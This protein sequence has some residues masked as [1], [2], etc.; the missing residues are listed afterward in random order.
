MLR[1]IPLL[2]L[3]LL[4]VGCRSLLPEGNPGEPAPSPSPTTATASP[5]LS[6]SPATSPDEDALV[7]LRQD[8]VALQE[9]MQGL[10]REVAELRQEVRDQQT[11]LDTSQ[12]QWDTNFSLMEQAVEKRLSQAG[13]S[14]GSSS[15]TTQIAQTVRQES[16]PAS[17]PKGLT[18]VR[19]GSAPSSSSS[20]RASSSSK[21]STGS[22]EDSVITYS[23]IQRKSTP[24]MEQAQPPATRSSTELSDLE[25]VVEEA[26]LKPAPPPPPR[27][28]QPPA[29]TA[30]SQ[31][32]ETPFDPDLVETAN[33]TVLQRIPGAINFYNKGSIALVQRRHDEAIRV[34]E[35]FLKRFPN[36]MNAP[37][38]QYW[39]GF[40]HFQ[41]GQFDEAEAAIRKM[42]RTYEHRPDTQGYKTSEGIFLLGRIAQERNELPLAKRYWQAAAKLYPGT[43]GADQANLELKR[44]AR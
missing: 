43:T 42:L 9:Y 37:K 6:S 16:A 39:A 14:S 24:N 21:A 23:L 36:E 12:Q 41:L 8:F 3:T 15:V 18:I 7:Q 20:S 2:L 33:P 10:E 27:K 32:E 26:D 1:T 29:R 34:F 17:Q 40:S 31:E 19:A 5:T 28:P 30:S 22:A 38:A 11:R 44:L 25:P 4:L 13:P 35:D